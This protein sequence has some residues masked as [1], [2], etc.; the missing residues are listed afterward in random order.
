MRRLILSLL[1]LSC[2]F[3]A[4]LC[5]APGESPVKWQVTVKMNGTDKG[6]VI[7]KARILSGWHLYGM[8][9]PEGG[10]KSTV[11]DMKES[12]GVE[13]TSPLKP[14]RAPVKV[15]DDMFGLDLTWWDSDISFRRDFKV[16]KKGD[17]RIAGKISFMSCNN[18]TCSPPKTQ[19]FDK[20]IK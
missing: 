11:I 2:G 18:E 16:K 9:L 14:D 7:F 8:N 3:V 20:I 6:T 1:L 12:S 5:Q 13:F 4:G 10:P 19:P 15:H 17:A